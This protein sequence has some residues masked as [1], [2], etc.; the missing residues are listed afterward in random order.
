MGKRSN[1]EGHSIWALS[2]LR[3]SLLALTLGFTAYI[4]G[5]INCTVYAPLEHVENTKANSVDFG[6][7]TAYYQETTRRR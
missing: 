6:R 1:R 2:S 7:S 5:V 4:F 3:L